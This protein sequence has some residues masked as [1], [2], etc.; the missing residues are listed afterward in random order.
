VRLH[1]LHPALRRTLDRRRDQRG[2]T[3]LETIITV[4]L[5]ATW[6]TAVVLLTSALLTSVWVHKRVIQAGNAA[7]TIAEALD[8]VDY[9]ACGASFSVANYRS[10]PAVQSA[11][12]R[13]GDGWKPPTIA[14]EFLQTAETST[15]H[16]A[17]AAC[18]GIDQGVQ[19]V[20][21]TVES[22]GSRTAKARVVL[23]KRNDRC[24]VG[25]PVTAG[26]PC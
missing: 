10:R 21:V 26:Q 6:L 8:Q 24:P 14:V 11:I 16:A 3:L 5:M 12:A 9:Q 15:T 1:R 7:T 20:T 25:A 18:P 2:E 17:F 4:M 23:I 22:S 19:R 13:I